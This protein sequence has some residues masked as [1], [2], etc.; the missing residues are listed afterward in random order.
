M[1]RPLL[2]SLLALSSFVP[3]C[4]E[5][6]ES[7]VDAGTQ[8]VVDAG[9]VDGGSLVVDAGPADAGP[10]DAGPVD[11]GPLDAGPTPDAGVT[12][13]ATSNQL[14]NPQNKVS[15]GV[16]NVLST[17]A[18]E[19]LLFIDAAAG[20]ISAEATNPRVYL[21][22]ANKARVDITDLQAPTDTTWDLS[23][24]R[25]VLFTNGGHGGRGQGAA[26]WLPGRT[27]S[28]V[29]AADLTT[30]NALVNEEF[31]DQNCDPFTD[32][33]GNVETTF[34][35]WYDYN[36]QTHVLTPRVGT[37]LVKGGNGS[38]W[39]VAVEA[40]YA[41]PDGGVGAAGGK[42]LLRYGPLQ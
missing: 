41:L 20:G 15:T 14:L 17:S 29:S 36:D 25:P 16:I 10:A 27:F 19:T 8:V 24:K 31:Y 18:T 34:S 4:G 38:P 23:L 3:G 37:Y 1:R 5:E 33:V 13:T 35:E 42:Y 26:H 39:K 11:A 40:Y 22:F 30:A 28:S 6:T 32:R 12:C 2:I 7:P 9:P 21:S